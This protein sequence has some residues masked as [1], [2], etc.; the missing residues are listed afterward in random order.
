MISSHKITYMVLLL[1]KLWAAGL[2]WKLV[3]ILGKTVENI[4]LDSYFRQIASSQVTLFDVFNVSFE[5]NRYLFLVFLLLTL[6]IAF[7]G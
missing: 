5:I 3:Y 6:N 7:F 4:V 1:L 2:D